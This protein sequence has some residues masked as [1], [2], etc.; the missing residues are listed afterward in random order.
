MW[1]FWF[2]H[3]KIRSN[4]L[5]FLLTDYIFPFNLFWSKKLTHLSWHKMDIFTNKHLC[6]DKCSNKCSWNSN[7]TGSNIIK[8]TLPSEQASR[9]YPHKYSMDVKRAILQYLEGLRKK[10]LKQKVTLHYKFGNPHTTW[11]LTRLKYIGQH[12]ECDP[13]TFRDA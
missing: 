4:C 11:F 1:R 9:T 13:V 2:C 12:L 5:H 8:N 10:S 6:R 3:S 7:D